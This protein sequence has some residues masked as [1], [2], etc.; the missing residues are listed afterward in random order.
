MVATMVE[1]YRY[2]GNPLNRLSTSMK[3]GI[4]FG[5]NEIQELEKY[6]EIIGP[7]EQLFNSLNAEKSSN[8]QKIYPSIKV[9]RPFFFKVIVCMLLSPSK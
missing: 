8:I 9:R 7:L 2:E 6:M 1:A 4:T 3:W 5:E